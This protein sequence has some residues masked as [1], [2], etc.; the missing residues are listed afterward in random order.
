[1]AANSDLAPAPGTV[2]GPGAAPRGR[3]QPA[4]LRSALRTGVRLLGLLLPTVAIAVGAF[5]NADNGNFTFSNLN[6]AAHGIYL[7]GFET[8][9]KLSVLAALVPGIVGFLIAYAIHTAKG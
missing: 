1:M 9:I 6:V 3:F 7:T 2:K 5:E 4:L 8:S